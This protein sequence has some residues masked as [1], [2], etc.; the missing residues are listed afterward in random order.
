MLCFSF[1]PGVFGTAQW[2]ERS[3]GSR[4][5]QKRACAN[6]RRAVVRCVQSPEKGVTAT[7]EAAALKAQEQEQMRQQEGELYCYV[8]CTPLKND[9]LERVLTSKVY[10]VAIETA[11]EAAPLLSARVGALVLLKRE[12]TQPVFSFKLRGAYNMMASVPK[13]RIAAGVVAASAGNHAQGVAM[14]AS[15]LGVHATI[16]M[17]L[18]TPQIKVDAVRSRGA[19]VVL[20]GDNFDAAKKLALELSE[21]DGRLFVP[22]FDHPD[23]IA[24]QGTVGTEIVRQSKAW[25][26]ENKQLKAVFVPVGGGGLIAGVAVVIKRLLPGVRVIGV[27]A[28]ESDALYQSMQA[29]KRVK[30]ASVG[31]FADGT[32]VIEVGEETWRL[33]SVLV[34]EVIRVTNDEIC[35]AMKDVFEDTRSIL[36]P[37]GALAVAAVKRYAEER[38]VDEDGA[39]IAV[40]SGANTNFDR[41][42]HVSERAE[43]GEGREAVL[44]VTIPEKPGSFREMLAALGAGTSVT[45]F[46][47]RYSGPDKA[48]VFVAFAVRNKA[49]IA[50]K[51]DSLR[52]AGFGVLDLTQDEMAKLHLRHLVGGRVQGHELD[53]E[54]AYRFEFPERPGA[55]MTFLLRMKSDWSISMFH[56]RNHGADRGRVFVG[57]RVPLHERDEFQ[58]FVQSLGYPYEDES[59]NPAYSLFL[60]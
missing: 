42:R 24:G 28:F 45:E 18:A 30:L 52:E 32:A 14:A 46:N 5:A 29:G 60:R 50:K 51:I 3:S 47:Y 7:G 44:A 23:I 41:L 40:T 49:Q 48:V 20:H 19:E 56:Y 17:P 31:T 34:D 9:Y 43:I 59:K 1:A 2:M 11:L 27:E 22:P 8:P 33:C 39:Y 38:G 57:I 26:L 15:K 4:S 21:K 13:S 37:S 54:V 35:A 10:D 6:R 16:V 58:N 53:D 12:D 55:L 36:E 25:E